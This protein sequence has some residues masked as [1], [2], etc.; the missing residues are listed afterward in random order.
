MNDPVARLTLYGSNSISASAVSTTRAMSLSSIVSAGAVSNVLMST[1]S[2]TDGDPC[3]HA[4]V[5][6]L[7]DV[8]LARR[9]RG[10]AHPHQHRVDLVR[11]LQRVI[12]ADEH[13]TTGDVDLL[14]RGDGD[15][16]SGAGDV[17]VA[18]EG[19]DAFD[20]GRDARRLHP[21]RIAGADDA[22]LDGAGESAEVEVGPHHELHR[23]PEAFEVDAGVDVDGLEVLHHGRPVVPVH[24]LAAIDDVVAEQGR[25]RHEEGIVEIEVGGDGAGSRRRSRRSGPATSRPGPSC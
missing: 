22:G 24:V 23:E 8:V 14:G 25:H 2:R 19:D 16:P 4:A 9:E 11:T 20:G 21:H 6:L 12:D 3:V 10:L 18:V 17:E 1:R 15:R 5:A 13:V 7:H